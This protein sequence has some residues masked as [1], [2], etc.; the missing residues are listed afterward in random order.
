MDDRTGLEERRQWLASFPETN[1]SPVIEVDENGEITF[2]NK[3]TLTTLKGLGLPENPALFVPVDKNEI[4][5]LLRESAE[6]QIYREIKLKDAFF[7]ENIALNRELRVA[8]IYASNITDR[9]KAEEALRKSEEEYRQLVE[10]APASIYEIASDGLRFIRVNDSMCRILGYTQKEM[11]EMN[12]FD[13]LDEESKVRFRERIRK[14][15]TGE[16]IDKS[17]AYRVFSKDG[18]ELWVI[19]SVK[20]NCKGGGA[21]VIAQDI[22][23]KRLIE[24]ALKD[25]EERLRLAQW[26]A[27][28]GLW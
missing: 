14:R 11:L 22:T 9:K 24:K 8:R 19:L 13:I 16:D 6:L 23:D 10:H 25:S 17:E 28:A 27:G 3:A 7:S 12:P 20:W 18:R 4:L 1:P 2:A 5:R 26:G 21:L 15:S